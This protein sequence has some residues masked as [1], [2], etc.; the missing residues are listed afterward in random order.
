MDYRGGSPRAASTPHGGSVGTTRET[1]PGHGRKISASPEDRLSSMIYKNLA[2]PFVTGSGAVLRDR[3]ERSNE[4]GARR[5]EYSRGF[6]RRGFSSSIP[7]TR[8][9]NESNWTRTHGRSTSSGREGGHFYPRAS[10]N[11][12]ANPFD[13]MRTLGRPEETFTMDGVNSSENDTITRDWRT[14]ST[15]WKGKDSRGCSLGLSLGAVVHDGGS[16]RARGRG[17]AQKIRERRARAR[18]GVE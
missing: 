5:S 8:G 10:K 7:V 4:V 17:C 14:E 6:S 11:P 9:N 13:R 12:P 15:G 3:R 16:R 18:H 2:N 1:G